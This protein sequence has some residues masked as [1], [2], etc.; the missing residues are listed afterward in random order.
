[1]LTA[2][3]PLSVSAHQASLASDARATSMSAFPNHVLV[4]EQQT[5][6]NYSTTTS[7]TANQ[8]G[9]DVSVRPGSTSVPQIPVPMAGPA[10]SPTLDTSAPAPRAS[11]DPTAAS[12][13]GG[14]VQLH[15]VAM[16]ALAWQIHTAKLDTDA[17]VPRAQMGQNVRL[18]QSMSVEFTTLVAAMD[19]VQTRLVAMSA[20]AR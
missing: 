19:V 2:L 16:A 17:N 8:A 7:A 9:K 14:S 10:L 11:L 3:A 15:H 4:L 13:V 20:S 6:C 12:T 5:V 18:T 1:M